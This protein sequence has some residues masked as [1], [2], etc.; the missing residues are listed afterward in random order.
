MGE[1]LNDNL[2]KYEEDH[3]T[4]NKLFKSGIHSYFN[5]RKI[6]YWPLYQPARSHVFYYE[7]DY[8]VVRKLL[9]LKSERSINFKA[10][11]KQLKKWIAA[12]KKTLAATQKKIKQFE[13]ELK[14]AEAA[15]KKA[16][17]KKT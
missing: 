9:H 13:S 5:K 14:K 2:P 15:E 1:D 8:A 11:S 7:N 17:P 12:N 6:S 10:S 4:G 3:I 16:A